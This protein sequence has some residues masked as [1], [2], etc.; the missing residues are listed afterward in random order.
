MRDI[1]ESISVIVSACNDKKGFDI[2][3]LDL[4][5]LTTVTDYFVIASGNSDSQVTSIANEVEKKMDE[6]NY[7]LIGREG[8]KEATWILLDYGSVVVHVFH[9][10][11]RE[12]YNLE[13]VWSDSREI[14]LEDIQ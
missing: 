10:E 3:I 2:K 5:E 8:Y 4:R 1:D 9:R 12:F 11:E 7:E 6:N 14:E 13:K